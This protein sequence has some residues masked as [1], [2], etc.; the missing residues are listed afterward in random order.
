M[1]WFIYSVTHTNE[2]NNLPNKFNPAR[3]A[4]HQG[5]ACPFSCSPLRGC[6]FE[7]PQPIISPIQ[8]IFFS[9]LH[10]TSSFTTAIN[11]LFA[12][13]AACQFEPP[14]P[15]TFRHTQKHFW[16]FAGSSVVLGDGCG[17]GCEWVDTYRWR[18]SEH[19][20]SLSLSGSVSKKTSTH[21]VALMSS[22]L[23]LSVLVTEKLNIFA[24]ACCLLLSA[25]VSKP[26]NIAALTTVTILKG[27]LSW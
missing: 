2:R 15:S 5:S 12:L 26:D 19:I 20:H 14:P 11:L 4:R 16:C 8:P 23:I 17:C 22:F 24:S 27:S 13:P 3:T 6:R 18:D 1:N 25:A 9:L 7:G 21:S 10:F